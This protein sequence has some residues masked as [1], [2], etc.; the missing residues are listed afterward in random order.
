MIPRKLWQGWIGPKPIPDRERSWCAQ[1][2]AMNPTWQ[3]TLF[4]N[5]MLER[6]GSDP[7][8]KALLARN[9]PMAFVVDRIRV[10][11]L[12][13]HG[14][15]WLDPDCQPVKPLDTISEIWD[16]PKIEFAMALRNPHRPLVAL[17][18]G[19]TLCDNT[20]ISTSQN[21]RLIRRIANLWSP[22]QLVVDG[23]ATGVEVLA[24]LNG[25]TDTIIGYRPFYDMQITPDTICLH[26]PHNL[27]SWVERSKERK[28]EMNLAP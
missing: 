15:V 24:N 27:G 8:V 14:G 12:K 10:L 21:S 20:F 11:L 9:E 25:V 5:E 7:Y 18:R 2:K 16:D 4:G 1:M 6:F 17:H 19:V 13:E 28:R 26:D 22:A 23:H 3:Y